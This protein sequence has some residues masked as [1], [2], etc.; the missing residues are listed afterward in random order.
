MKLLP[1]TIAATFDSLKPEPKTE[2][3]Q[4]FVSYIEENWIRGTV[5]LPETAKLTAAIE[6][7]ATWSRLT[8]NFERS[9]WGSCSKDVPI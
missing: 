3:L 6:R 8:A 4:K 1:E 7:I 5:W 9:H 2:P